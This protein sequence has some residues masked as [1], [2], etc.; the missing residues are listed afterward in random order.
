MYSALGETVRVHGEYVVTSVEKRKIGDF[1]V[2]FS[3]KYKTG[4][5]DLLA[6][7]TD[8][9][10]VRIKEGLSFKIAAE[11]VS[12]DGDL[13][14]A[15]IFLDSQQAGKIPVWLVSKKFI[16]RPFKGAKYIEMHAPTSDYLVF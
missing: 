10:H 7:E 6:L 9:L 4:R 14:Q 5:F 12:A 2:W 3:S 15:L 8:H 16:S 13:S 1:K 11:V